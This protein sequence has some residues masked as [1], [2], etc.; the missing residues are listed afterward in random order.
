MYCGVKDTRGGFGY[1]PS[2]LYTFGHLRRVVQATGIFDKTAA[3]ST[4]G[5]PFSFECIWECQP[6]PSSFLVEHA[7]HYLVHVVS[8]TSGVVLF[9]RPSC[10]SGLSPIGILFFLIC[11]SCGVGDA[12]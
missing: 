6:L 4:V 7:I 9:S 2:F 8:R 3:S 11:V 1:S 5:R 12:S 10:L